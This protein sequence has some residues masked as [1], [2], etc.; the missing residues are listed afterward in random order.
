MSLGELIHGEQRRDDLRTETG[1]VSCLESA[2]LPARLY[3]DALSDASTEL[4]LIAEHRAAKDRLSAFGVPTIALEGSDIGIF[5]PVIEPMPT[6]PMR[7]RCGNTYAGC[8]S[9][10][11]SGKSS[12]SARSNSSRSTCWTEPH[13]CRKEPIVA[14]S[15]LNGAI[16]R[17]ISTWCP[18]RAR[19]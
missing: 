3:A 18:I 12:A 13:L 9:N 15:K 7:T 4:D 1:V 17:P 11:I 6:A 5:G 10:R 2:G 19:T 14:E 16:P 8:S